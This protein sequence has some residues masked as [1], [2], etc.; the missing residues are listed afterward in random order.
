MRRKITAMSLIILALNLCLSGCNDSK[1]S[2]PKPVS[3]PIIAAQKELDAANSDPINSTELSKVRHAVLNASLNQKAVNGIC[4]YAIGSNCALVSTD[5]SVGGN[6]QIQYWFVSH[7]T[8]ESGD[9][10]WRAQ[11]MKG[12]DIDIVNT[13]IHARHAADESSTPSDNSTPDDYSD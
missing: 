9:G 10:Y 3:P 12:N 1:P 7:F 2:V 8:P 5:V 13:V 6:H 4:T 11:P